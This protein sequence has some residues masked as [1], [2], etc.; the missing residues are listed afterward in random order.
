MSQQA[1][2]EIDRI[3]ATTVDFIVE[4]AEKI[5]NFG[6]IKEEYGNT[7]ARMKQ[8]ARHRPG[9]VK[10]IFGG[11]R[12][13][14]WTYEM[15]LGMD[16]MMTGGPQYAEVVARTIQATGS[17]GQ[18]FFDG[19]ATDKLDIGRINAYGTNRKQI[20]FEKGSSQIEVY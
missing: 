15:R 16:G 7:L 11:S 6:Y 18:S 17:A 5:P 2:G 1:L 20:E 3:V 9:A 12:A 10:R 8:A 19:D 4:L 14:A 13:R